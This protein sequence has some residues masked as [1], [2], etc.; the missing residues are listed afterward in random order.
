MLKKN[1]INFIDI[2]KIDVQG[3]ESEVL[4]GAINT[5]KNKVKII[6]LEIIFIDYYEKKSAFYEIEKILIPL[7]F[8]LYTISSPVIND[9]DEKL[10]WLDAIYVKS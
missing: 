10:K 3:F 5:L 4:E 8:D 1:D 6:E 7:K 2:L 9:T